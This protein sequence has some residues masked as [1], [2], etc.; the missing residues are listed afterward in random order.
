ME[1]TGLGR[2][3]RGNEDGV[4]PFDEIGEAVEGKRPM[5]GDDTP[6]PFHR[7]GERAGAGGGAVRNACGVRAG[8]QVG[9]VGG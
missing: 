6:R 2:R 1:F 4:V 3:G 8:A 5:S 9:F 7:M